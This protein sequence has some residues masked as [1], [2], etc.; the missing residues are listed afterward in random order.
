VP[1]WVFGYFGDFVGSNAVGSG[2]SLSENFKGFSVKPVKPVIGTKPHK[3]A[4]VFENCV[5]GV[6]T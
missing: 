1:V 2:I 4:T 6:L 3:S 5:D